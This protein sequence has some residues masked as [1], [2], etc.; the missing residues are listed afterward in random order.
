MF[1]QT[2][3][4]GKHKQIGNQGN[5]AYT[6]QVVP[7][8]GLG[9]QPAGSPLTFDNLTKSLLGSAGLA[10]ALSVERFTDCLEH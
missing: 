10:S 3:T 1:L 7:C 5:H 4:H 6:H 9:G 2:R 8:S